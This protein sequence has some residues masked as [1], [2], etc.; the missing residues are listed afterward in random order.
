M[1]NRVKNSQIE[2]D[3]FIIGTEEGLLQRMA[4]DFPKKQFYPVRDKLICYNMKK[5]TLEL[6]KHVLE[7]LDDPMFEVKVPPEIAKKAILPLE[8]MLQMS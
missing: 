8:K 5:H 2:E 7:N 1:Y 6:I 4:K 3:K